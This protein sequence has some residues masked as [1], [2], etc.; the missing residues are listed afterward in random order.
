MYFPGGNLIAGMGGFLQTWNW[1]FSSPTFVYPINWNYTDV[2]WARLRV[3][4]ERAPIW[5]SGNFGAQRMRVVCQQW[6][7]RARLW[8]DFNNAPED[9]FLLG[10]TLAMKLVVCDYSRYYGYPIIRPTNLFAGQSVW[11]QEP[12]VANGSG[13]APKGLSIIPQYVAP[14]CRYTL[15]APIVSSLGDDGEEAIVTQDI[16]LAG[17]SLLF[18][19]LSQQDGADYASYVGALQTRGELAT[20]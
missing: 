12:Y 15:A 3:S 7:I 10:D 18:P 13:Y 16:E 19:I 8:W 17:D 11:N 20:N 2:A 5:G 4:D 9:N 14:A 6:T 1:R